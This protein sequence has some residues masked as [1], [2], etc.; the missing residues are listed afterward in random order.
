MPSRVDDLD[1]ERL[2]RRQ[3][4]AWDRFAD[5]LKDN[6]PLDQ[7]TAYWLSVQIRNQGLFAYEEVLAAC[8]NRSGDQQTVLGSVANLT[9]W[10]T[11]HASSD[12]VALGD[13]ARDRLRKQFAGQQISSVGYRDL[14]A[15]DEFTRR[16]PEPGQR[17]AILQGTLPL[18][19][20]LVAPS[21]EAGKG[22]ELVLNMVLESDLTIPERRMADSLI[23]A[24]VVQRRIT[25]DRQR[26][27]MIA[28]GSILE[29]WD[30]FRSRL[31]SAS[32]FIGIRE[33]IRQARRGWEVSGRSLST[34]Q[35]LQADF[36]EYQL[37][38][39]QRTW[40]GQPNLRMLQLCNEW[41]DYER[42]NKT[43][44]TQLEDRITSSNEIIVQLNERARVFEK[45]LADQTTLA[46][47]QANQAASKLFAYMGIT[48]GIAAA[49]STG[50]VWYSGKASSEVETLTSEKNDAN[51]LVNDLR[52]QITEAKVK[53][54]RHDAQV[55]IAK[56][57]SLAQFAGGSVEKWNEAID[58]YTEAIALDPGAA[59]AYRWRAKARQAIRSSDFRY[60]LDDWVKYY[61]LVPDMDGRIE[62]AIL[63][64]L[65]LYDKIKSPE[66]ESI[67]I[68]QLR[69]FRSEL[70]ELQGSLSSKINSKI[71]ALEN[72][73]SRLP[74][75]RIADEGRDLV[76]ALKAKAEGT[77]KSSSVPASGG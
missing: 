49:I 43:Q 27:I 11:D 30:E 26:G 64:A 45:N 35:Q 9:R 32:E 62:N 70:N 44:R 58:I 71:P 14:S 6:I 33:S 73:V 31:D 16:Y 42:N 5:L 24:G 76:T 2:E 1:P 52:K 22:T 61:S 54:Q 48:I 59:E 12:G 65:E 37:S 38:N 20:Q 10:L 67:I 4:H 68:E 23:S 18:L 53:Q 3:R 17:L 36:S 77:I 8:V 56:G 40:M 13:A 63:P 28:D 25:E 39:E 19:S 50:L 34:L 74:K 60:R 46:Q 55:L 47:N 51:R 7:Q 69:L 66:I 15:W 57:I 72:M 21:G 75:S 41:R 29:R